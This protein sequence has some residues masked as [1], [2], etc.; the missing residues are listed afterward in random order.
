LKDI[1]AITFDCYGTLI[2]WEGGAKQS[3]RVLL[4]KRR[5][6]DKGLFRA[7]F[8][9]E[10]FGAWERA[11]WTRI[12]QSY[13]CYR[14]IAAE[15]LEQVA[16]EHELPLTG[17]DACAFANSIATWQPFPD[18]AAALAKLKQK[19]RLGLISNID[20]DIL[21]ASAAR[22]GVEFD[23]LMTAERARAYKPSPLPFQR[24]LERLGLPAEQ[25]AHAAFGFEYDITTASTLGFR[26]ILVRRHRRKFPPAPAPDLIVADLAELAQTFG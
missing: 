21:A 14:Q 20:D 23:L 2:D 24:A 3:L 13:T 15:S 1:R 9:D 12:Q 16:A 11:Q 26:T 4:Q 22:L 25:V 8:L 7:E 18:T 5:P 17:A 6:R 19:V 10:L